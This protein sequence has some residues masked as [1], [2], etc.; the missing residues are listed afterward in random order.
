MMTTKLNFNPISFSSAMINDLY[1]FLKISFL[2]L[3]A[4]DFVL[5]SSF[6]SVDEQIVKIK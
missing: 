4:L 1:V 5:I 2:I 6:P 3:F